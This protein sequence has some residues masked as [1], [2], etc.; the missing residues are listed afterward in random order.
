MCLVRC[1]NSLM[2]A[3]SG[4]ERELVVKQGD[5]DDKDELQSKSKQ[6]GQNQK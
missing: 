3:V 5:E 6:V 1:V 4:G 2:V